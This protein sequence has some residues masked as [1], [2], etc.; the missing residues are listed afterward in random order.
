AAL[1]LRTAAA[2]VGL[3]PAEFRERVVRSESLTRS[4]GALRVAGGTVHRPVF[5]QAFGDLA[6]E[7]RLGALVPPSLVAG[8]LPDNTGDLD[9]LEGPSSQTNAAAFSPDRRLA[10]LASADRSVR[11][12]ETASGRELRRFVGHGASV[13]AV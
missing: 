6:R 11:L 2:E 10:L 4:L 12:I 8:N 9:P 1:D 3:P 7:F 13:W 5:Q